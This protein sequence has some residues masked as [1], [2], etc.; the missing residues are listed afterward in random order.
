[1][2]RRRSSSTTPLTFFFWAFF[3]AQ[4]LTVNQSF[5]NW[6]VRTKAFQLLYH[7][8]SD[9]PTT[10]ITQKF[11][12]LSLPT[13]PHGAKLA[14]VAVQYGPLTFQVLQSAYPELTKM[15]GE[16]MCTRIEQNNRFLQTESSIH[17]PIPPSSKPPTKSRFCTVICDLQKLQNGWWNLPHWRANKHTKQSIKQT[18]NFNKQTNQAHKIGKMGCRVFW[19]TIL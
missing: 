6:Q 14:V 19:S 5:C 10:T 16:I 2:Y 3:L 8:T 17:T 15:D 18:N 1:M 9:N 11:V 7:T 13:H 12:S 4:I